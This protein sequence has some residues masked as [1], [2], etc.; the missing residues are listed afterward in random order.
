MD[1]NKLKSMIKKEAVTANIIDQ[2]KDVVRVYKNL[3]L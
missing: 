2:V 1:L 3:Q